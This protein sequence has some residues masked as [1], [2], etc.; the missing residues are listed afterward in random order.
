MFTFLLREN[1]IN[2]YFH[3]IRIDIGKKEEKPIIIKCN[4]IFHL[5]NQIKKDFLLEQNLGFVL[6]FTAL[7]RA[8]FFFVF[9]AKKY[10]VLRTAVQKCI[11]ALPC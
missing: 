7:R 8:V 5:E 4:L 1:L 10:L 6:L 3:R 11:L 2:F 9:C